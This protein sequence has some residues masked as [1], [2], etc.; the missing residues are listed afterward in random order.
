MDLLIKFI[1]LHY[2]VMIILGKFEV[3]I[4]LGNFGKWLGGKRFFKWLGHF[5]YN[6]L[7]CLFCTI[8]FEGLLVV[9]FAL[10]LWGG[11][12]EYLFFPLMSTGALFLFN[13]QDTNG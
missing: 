7:E 1:L 2:S 6:L 9:P 12:W 10:L 5:F 8:H 11:C 4:K 3:R 13:K